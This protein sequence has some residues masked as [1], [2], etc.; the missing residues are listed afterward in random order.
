VLG[1]NVNNVALFLA[2]ASLIAPI[3]VLFDAMAPAFI[4]GIAALVATPPPR[5]CA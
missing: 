1:G 5:P 3:I 2:A 4:R